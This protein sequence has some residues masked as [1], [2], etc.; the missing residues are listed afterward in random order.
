[1]LGSGQ[2]A[3]SHQRLQSDFSLS[4]DGTRVAYVQLIPKE[5]G[6]YGGTYRIDVSD[7]DGANA[8]TVS[9]IFPFVRWVTWNP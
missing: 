3:I 1:M 5:D 2:C 9:E 7:L 6:S 8:T 4:A